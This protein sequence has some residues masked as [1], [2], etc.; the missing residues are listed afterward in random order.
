[1][2]PKAKTGVKGN[3]L[4]T[5]GVAKTADKKKGSEVKATAKPRMKLS[6]RP[7]TKTVDEY[8]QQVPDPKLQAMD[9]T[10]LK[11]MCSWLEWHGVKKTNPDESVRKV[12]HTFQ[13]ATSIEKRELLAGFKNNKGKLIEWAKKM[14]IQEVSFDDTE[15]GSLADFY[16]R[17]V[18]HCLHVLPCLYGSCPCSGPPDMCLDRYI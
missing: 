4:K 11:Q 9:A 8:G 16:F 12:L 13:N 17:T 14:T 2:G 3:T 6:P 7:P 18:G 10:H 15:T 1:M 5:A